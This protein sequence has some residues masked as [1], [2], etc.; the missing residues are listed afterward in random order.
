MSTPSF[1]E[2]VNFS[3][4]ARSLFKSNFVCSLTWVLKLSIWSSSGGH[5][6]WPNGSQSCFHLVVFF[7]FGSGLRF[8]PRHSTC[9][10]DKRFFKTMGVSSLITALSIPSDM[11][12]KFEILFFTYGY[13]LAA[14]STAIA[15]E[16]PPICFAVVIKVYRSGVKRSSIMLRFLTY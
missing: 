9:I 16:S 4:R 12:W 5:E 10:S 8:I 6:H 7:I 11:V 13:S 1:I 14:S 15:N 3:E 2:E